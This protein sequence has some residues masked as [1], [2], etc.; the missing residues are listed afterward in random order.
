MKAILFLLFVT[1]ALSATNYRHIEIY[2][3]DGSA[4]SKIWVTE[5]FLHNQLIYFTNV[6]FMDITGLR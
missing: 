6:T 1:F 3:N 4:S 5:E 2:P